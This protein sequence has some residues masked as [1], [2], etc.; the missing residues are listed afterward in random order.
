MRSNNLIVTSLAILGISIMAAWFWSNTQS[1]STAAQAASN[2]SGP[3]MEITVAGEAKGVIRIQLYQDVAPLHVERLVTLAKDGAYDGIVFHRVIDGFMAQTGDV[4]FGKAGGDLSRAGGGKSTYANL[5]A[6]FSKLPFERGTVGMAR[7]AALDSANSQFFID[8][9]PAPFLNGEY[10]VVGQVID[11]FDVLDAIK[12]GLGPN[13][14]VLGD[15]DVMTTV[16]IA[17]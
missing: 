2:H 16:T 17:K 13:G 6:E 12:R 4:E 11:G 3:I 9:A 10:T 5:A 1:G 15:P 8:F 7:A 14:S